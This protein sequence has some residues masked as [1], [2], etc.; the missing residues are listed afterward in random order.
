MS[1]DSRT[2]FDTMNLV[3]SAA[4]KQVSIVLFDL[5]SRLQ[6]AGDLMA[7]E[8]VFEEAKAWSEFSREGVAE[9]E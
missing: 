9:V 6:A 2:R 4:A 1:I 5:S 7:A 8:I 3:N